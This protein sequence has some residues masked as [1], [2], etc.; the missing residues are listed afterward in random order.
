VERFPEA[1]GWP[2]EARA[3]LEHVAALA[4]TVVPDAATGVSYGAPSLLVDGKALIG[5]SRGARHLSLVPFSPPA[6]DAVRDELDGFAASKGVIRFTPEH[7][8]PD[9]VV[10]RLV[11]LRLAEI[12]GDS[13][14]GLAA[15]A[16]K[17]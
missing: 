12:R 1:D 9:D 15:G 8:V 16:A 4:R 5:V 6:I 13:D 11:H 17:G 3:A 2:A 7:P 10:L 14:A